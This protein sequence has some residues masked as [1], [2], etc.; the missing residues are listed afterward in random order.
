[1]NLSNHAPAFPVMQEDQSPSKANQ[2]GEA[3]VKKTAKIV[4]NLVLLTLL[5]LLLSAVCSAS[6][7]WT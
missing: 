2:K 6:A 5:V 1:M 3:A 4:L 7:V